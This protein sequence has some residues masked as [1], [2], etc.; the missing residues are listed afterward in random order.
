MKV[1]SIYQIISIFTG[2][3]KILKLFPAIFTCREKMADERIP[4][5]Q[6]KCQAT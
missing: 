1:V 3:L 4:L 6:L 2:G 5:M